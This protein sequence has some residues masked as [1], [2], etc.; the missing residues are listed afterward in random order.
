M[1][2]RH[3]TTTPASAEALRGQLRREGCRPGA[4]AHLPAEVL[5]ID[6]AAYSHQRCPRCRKRLAVEPWTDGACYRL[7]CRCPA[8][9]FAE[10]A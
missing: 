3:S 4:P 9:A 1:W 6:L 10:E 5:D 8:C 2:N 7:L